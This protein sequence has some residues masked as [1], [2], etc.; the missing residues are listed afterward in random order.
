[1]ENRKYLSEEPINSRTDGK[2]K[3]FAHNIHGENTRVM[4]VERHQGPD[5]F[6]GHRF[7]RMTFTIEFIDIGLTITSKFKDSER[8]AL[9]VQYALDL[10]EDDTFEE[11]YKAT[12]LLTK[13]RLTRSVEQMDEMLANFDKGV[14]T[15]PVHK[16]NVG[17][18]RSRNEVYRNA[19]NSID[20]TTKDLKYFEQYKRDGKTLHDESRFDY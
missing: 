10:L 14:Y 2:G 7:N 12:L 11:Y 6:N 20:I 17:E 5:K 15:Y 18:Y 8:D 1:M 3:T 16:G 4:F 19:V 13:E 9:L